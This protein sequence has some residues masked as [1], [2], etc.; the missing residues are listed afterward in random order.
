MSQTKKYLPFPIFLLS[1]GVVGFG[2]WYTISS[3]YLFNTL[4]YIALG[5]ILAVSLLVGAA[6]ATFQISSWTLLYL[7]LTGG[8]KT[9][10]KIVRLVAGWPDKFKKQPKA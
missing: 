8:E 7:R 9:Y 2:I 1:I 5:S 10:S 4:M 6:L 3:P